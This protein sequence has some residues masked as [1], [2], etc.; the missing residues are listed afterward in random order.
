MERHK[1]GQIPGWLWLEALEHVRVGHKRRYRHRAM[2]Y[3]QTYGTQD[4]EVWYRAVDLTLPPFLARLLALR[5]KLLWQRRAHRMV[6][7]SG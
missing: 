7:P 5:G 6:R 1:V 3:R 2:L 4:N